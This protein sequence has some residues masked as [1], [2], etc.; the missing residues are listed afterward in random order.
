MH[1]YAFLLE[2]PLLL[3]SLTNADLC[4]AFNKPGINFQNEN[5]SLIKLC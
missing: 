1:D 5:Y 2:L 3:L 4:L